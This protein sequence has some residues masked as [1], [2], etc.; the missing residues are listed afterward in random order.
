[1][2]RAPLT[3]VVALS[4]SESKSGVGV[5]VAERLALLDDEA[6]T[7][8]RLGVC[9]EPRALFGVAPFA[10]LLGVPCLGVLLLGVPL[11]EA[12]GTMRCLFGVCGIRDTK[13]MQ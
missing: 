9:D 1:M 2:T 13:T 10:P 3:G 5:R 4:S 6:A 12:T 7:P 8:F 11:F